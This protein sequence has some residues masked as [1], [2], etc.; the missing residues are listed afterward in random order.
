MT[1]AKGDNCQKFDILDDLH[2]IAR[3]GEDVD[4]TG[5]ISENAIRRAEII[6]KDYAQI[7]AKHKVDSALAVCTSSMRLAKN[8]L[9]V[10]QLFKKF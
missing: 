10:L 9:E 7:M 6:L 1:I 2:S 3:L 4:K 5:F 8:N